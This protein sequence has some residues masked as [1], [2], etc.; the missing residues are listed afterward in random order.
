MKSDISI[1]E[2]V[3]RLVETFNDNEKEL[4][5][6]DR[7]NKAGLE[8]KV[9]CFYLSDLCSEFKI[10][11][12]LDLI[13]ISYACEVSIEVDPAVPFIQIRLPN[14]WEQRVIVRLGE[15]GNLEVSCDRPLKYSPGRFIEVN[16][17]VLEAEHPTSVAF[18]KAKKESSHAIEEDSTGVEEAFQE[19][20]GEILHSWDIDGIC[21]IIPDYIEHPFLTNINVYVDIKNNPQIFTKKYVHRHLAIKDFCHIM[22]GSISSRWGPVSLFIVFNEREGGNYLALFLKNI[23]VLLERP[24]SENSEIKGCVES[25]EVPGFLRQ[26]KC[27][28]PGC[29]FFL[30]IYGTK[31]AIS[32]K[33]F[34]VVY[35]RLFDIFNASLVPELTLDIALRAVSES[36]KCLFISPNTFKRLHVRPNYKLALCI[37]TRFNYK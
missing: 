32:N 20:R 7:E 33:L 29:S 16:N 22:L 9:V 21:G 2:L 14:H 34:F 28:Y 37:K 18:P 8:K 4:F 31:D 35:T 5:L 26:L 30:E 27:L 12:E 3:N 15:D 6:L 11:S 23:A 13:L 25:H 36:F 17:F 10:Y 19:Y 1:N 24:P